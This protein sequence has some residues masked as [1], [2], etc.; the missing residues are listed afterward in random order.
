MNLKERCVTKTCFNLENCVK[1]HNAWIEQCDKNVDT[2]TWQA[3]C[4]V[5]DDS[6]RKVFDF[7]ICV[8]VGGLL[9]LK[10]V[11][12]CAKKDVEE[13]G[14]AY[15][16]IRDQDECNKHLRMLRNKHTK[17]LLKIQSDAVMSALQTPNISTSKK[18]SI[19]G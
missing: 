6:S 2:N 10:L 11:A 1:S 18:Q 3:R 16:Q 12:Y 19:P 4:D 8:T 15:A 14:T 17:E 9:I 13:T 7:L 5:C